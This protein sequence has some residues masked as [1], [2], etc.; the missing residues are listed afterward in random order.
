METDLLENVVLE[1]TNFNY[2]SSDDEPKKPQIFKCEICFK[3]YKNRSGLWKHKKT[4][5]E[6]I[7]LELK[8]LDETLEQNIEEPLLSNIYNMIESLHN[9]NKKI[10]EL[11][12]ELIKKNT[13]LSEQIS[14]LVK[15]HAILKLLLD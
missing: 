6:N 9:E 2:P 4:C 15:H 7:N 10:I 1:N 3:E 5:K 8:E 13:L 12:E 11:N 14:I